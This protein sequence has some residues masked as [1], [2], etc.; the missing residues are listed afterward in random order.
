M[1]SPVDSHQTPNRKR[2]GLALLPVF[3]LYLFTT[4]TEVEAQQ[5]YFRSDASGNLVQSYGTNASALA[6]LRQPA[7]Q[8]AAVGDNR[9]FSLIAQG[10]VPLNYQW[11]FNSNNIAGA[12]ADTLA[13]TN[14]S[15][16]DF[17]AYRVIVGDSVNSITSSNAL[18]QLDSDH[19]GMA[20]AWEIANFGSI[21]NRNGVHDFDGDGVS[22]LDE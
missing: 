8:V 9:A 11:Q 19:D 22:D 5:V 17:G 20:D 6:L 7:S 2:R 1:N 12:T 3:A 16:G 21:T 15:P 18:L 4:T 10:A 13:L 14:L